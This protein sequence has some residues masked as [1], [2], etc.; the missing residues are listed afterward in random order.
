[1]EYIVFGIIL[2]IVA[3]GSTFIYDHVKAKMVEHNNLFKSKPSTPRPENKKVT[4]TPKKKSNE[5]QL[6][7]LLRHSLNRSIKVPNPPTA[8]AWKPGDMPEETT[9]K[10]IQREFSINNQTM[11]VQELI[12]QLEQLKKKS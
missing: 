4:P 7:E 8:K 5:E 3:V 6:E 12:A 2:F 11:T 1:M 10:T 9:Y